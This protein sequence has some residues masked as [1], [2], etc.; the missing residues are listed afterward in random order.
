MSEESREGSINRIMPIDANSLSIRLETQTILDRIRVFLEGKYTRATMN[1]DGTVTEELIAIGDPKANQ[2]GIQSIMFWLE[3]KFNAQMVQGNFDTNQ[4]KS[5][6]RRVRT[7]FANSLMINR[8]NYGIKQANY[9]EI[10]DNCMDALEIY[11]SRVIGAGDRKAITQTTE[12][13]EVHQL[14]REKK[15][16]I[17]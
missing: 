8:I 6:L 10:M 16:G 2:K 12:H 4:Y 17:I 5:F 15:F 14:G 9:S 7:N 13:K 3:S 1:D 11:L